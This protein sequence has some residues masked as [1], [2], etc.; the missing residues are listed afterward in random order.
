MGC[1]RHVSPLSCSHMAVCSALF[2]TLPSEQLRRIPISVADF[3]A[4]GISCFTGGFQI[5]NTFYFLTRFSLFLMSHKLPLLTP[6]YKQVGLC[7]R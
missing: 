1:V 3:R 5:Y 6:T 2:T 7:L 4:R